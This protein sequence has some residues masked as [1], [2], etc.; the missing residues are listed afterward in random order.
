MGSWMAMML[1]ESSRFLRSA[2]SCGVAVNL[3]LSTG[4]R[5]ANAQSIWET[6]VFINDW[7]PTEAP[8]PPVPGGLPALLLSILTFLIPKVVD[9]GLSF[10]NAH[11]QEKKKEEE[12]KNQ[13][14]STS[15]LAAAD[16]FYRLEGGTQPKM[17]LV[18]KDQCI[19]FVRGNFGKSTPAPNDCPQFKQAALRQAHTCRWLHEKGVYPSTTG[20]DG[21]VGIYLEAKLVFSEEGTSFRLQPNYF[22]YQLPLVAEESPE[23]RYDTTFTFAFEPSAAGQTVTPFGLAILV[24]QQLKRSTILDKDDLIGKS[25]GWTPIPPLA[26]AALAEV[27]RVKDMYDTQATL[28]AKVAEFTESIAA[29]QNKAT[30]LRAELS[31]APPPPA[32]PVPTGNVFRDGLAQA[33]ALA[34]GEKFDDVLFNA[35]LDTNAS[36]A[37][38]ISTESL[39]EAQRKVNRQVEVRSNASYRAM[40]TELKSTAEEGLKRHAEKKKAE[41]DLARKIDEIGTWAAG[42][43]LVAPFTVRATMTEQ[44]FLPKNIF[45]LTAAAAFAA[46]QKDLGGFISQSITQGLG[47]E[48]KDAQIKKIED[49]GKL[50]IAAMQSLNAARDAQFELDRLPADATESIKRQRQLALDSAKINANITYLKAGLDPPYPEA[51]GGH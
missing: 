32:Q 15:A 25:S 2:I 19:V 29:L 51:F 43:R 13:P 48:G 26:E 20:S 18:M 24:F 14:K 10:A 11:I 16:G 44:P 30:R 5:S 50:L 41:D 47:L 39:Q 28:S 34:S 8:P 1:G 17:A 7:C 40:V 35:Q 45:F 3:L 38:S 9:F 49:H 23:D 21:A 27:K 42:K 22:S 12:E 46:S 36:T 33:T 37:G 4:L 6:R 31:A